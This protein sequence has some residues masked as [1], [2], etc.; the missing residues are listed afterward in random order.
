MNLP[1]LC[2]RRPVMTT[3]IMSALLI[4]GI[5]GYRALPV[6]DLPSVDF[7][8]ISVSA[9]LPGANPETMAASVAAPL[10]RQFSTIAGLD[11][12]T[13]SSAL[14][15]TSITLQFALDRDIDAAAQDVQAAIAATL[16]R[17]PAEMPAPPSYRKVN[18]ADSPIFYLVLRSPVLPLS[19]VNEYA[20]TMIGQ[21]LSTVRGVA[22]V[23]VFGSQKYAVRI[24][25]APEALAAR[26]ITLDEVARAVAQGNSTIAKGALDGPR[27]SYTIQSNSALTNAAGF[28]PLVVAWRNGAPVRLDQLGHVVDSV[29]NDKV[30]SWFRDTRA[31]ILAVQRQPGTNTVEIIDDIR[32]LLPAFRAQIPASVELEVLFDRS[33]T[34]RH[35]INDVQ[36]SLVLATALVLMVIF[37]FL[38]NAT[39]TLIPSLAMPLAIISTFAGMYVLGYSLNNLSLMA[40]TLS[41]GFVVDDAIVMLENIVRHMEKGEPPMQAAIKGSR[42]IGFTIISMTLSLVAVFIPV[43]FMGGVLGRLLHEFAVT[44]TMAVLVS[45]FV[46]LTLTPMMASRFIKPQQ[47]V[48]HGRVYAWSERFFNG[49]LA[50]YE[51]S[52]QWVLHHRFATLMVALGTLVIAALLFAVTPK[53]FLPPEDTGIIFGSTEAN[54]DTSFAAMAERQQKV[55]AIV[56]ADPD[57]EGF[58]SAVGA[59]GPTSTGN[60]GRLFIHLKEKPQRQ[61]SV[62]QIIASLRPKL[63]EVPGIRVFLQNPPTI[64]LGGRLTKSLYQYT[65]QGQDLQELYHWV[66]LLEEKLKTLP[67]LQEVTSDLQISSLQAVVNIDRERASALGITAQQIDEALSYAYGTRQVSTIYTPSDDYK[68]ILGVEAR[69]QQEPGEI[70]LLHL[71][72]ANGQLVPLQA[73]VKITRGTGPLTVNHQGQLPAV[74]LS[75]NLSPG[76]ALSEAVSVI[77]EAQ[78][79][80]GLP[81]TINGSFQGTAQVFQ[82]SMQGLGILLLVAIVVIYIVLGVLYESF[83]HPVTILSGLPSAAV[84]ALLTLTLFGLELSVTAFV[85]VIMLV[86]IVKKNAIMMIDFAIS[87]ERHEGKAPYDA[88]VE[89]CRLRFRPIMMTTMAALMGTLPIALGIGAG[90][91]TRQPLGLAVVGGLLLSQFLTLYITPVIYLYLERL[92]GGRR[93]AL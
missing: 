31:I 76:T 80:I 89:A 84:G 66:P 74:T 34:I 17:L 55:A 64:R 82:Q 48:H 25:V 59:G 23:S 4:F 60:A 68:V 53:G 79:E 78:A 21:R 36:F 33:Q 58:M 13:S 70:A 61:R 22:Q 29:E 24:N 44:I 87:A 83:I 11:N 16:R 18:P 56:A 62:D 71:R 77:N 30:A 37:L 50:L 12:M 67:E 20:E 73:V 19:Q 40:L 57:V 26:N 7:P 10:E 14:G 27:Q 85:G 15:T 1:E 72:A 52:L 75:F 51:R 43:L 54:P 6:S 81:V 5:I 49:W 69:Y 46:S 91:E 39:A 42:E 9:S 88:I 35:S 47:Q 3:L 93:Q 45:G 32:K 28:K 92:A 41:V 90:A 86:G 65:L 38:R 2:I 63:A 8:T